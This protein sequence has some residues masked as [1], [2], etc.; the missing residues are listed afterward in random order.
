MGPIPGFVLEVDY[1]NT[2]AGSPTGV[3]V[4][5]KSTSNT[6]L[7]LEHVAL[8][9]TSNTKPQYQNPI[10]EA[11][12]YTPLSVSSQACFSALISVLIS[13]F[14]IRGDMNECL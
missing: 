14:H 8:K 5:N 1:T 3:L 13:K 4:L 6:S 2:R 10:P 12:E 7:V 9:L 11:G